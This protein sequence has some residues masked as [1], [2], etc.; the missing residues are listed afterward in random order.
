MLSDERRCWFSLRSD[1]RIEKGIIKC[2]KWKQELKY[3][4]QKTT[5][6]QMTTDINCKMNSSQRL[7]DFAG[8]HEERARRQE[9]LRRQRDLLLGKRMKDRSVGM[10]DV[11][12]LEDARS[13]DAI[14][15]IVL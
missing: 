4:A 8:D 6:P 5:P 10:E 12:R 7:P 11:R 1:G 3:T 15:C 2:H 13:I 9:H 14:Y